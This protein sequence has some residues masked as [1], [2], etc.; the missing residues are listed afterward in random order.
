[1][2]D[3]KPLRV[4]GP[5]PITEY[6]LIVVHYNLSHKYILHT[7]IIFIYFRLCWV[8]VAG[9]GLSLVVLQSMG[10]RHAG[11]GSYGTWASVVE[12]QGL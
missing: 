3:P 4:D 9:H 10:S 5:C 1:M 7:S 6:I 2:K 12:A 8:F 11:F